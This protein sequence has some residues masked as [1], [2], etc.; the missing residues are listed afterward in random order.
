MAEFIVASL[1]INQI[2]TRHDQSGGKHTLH[3]RPE[4]EVSAREIVREVVE[5]VPPE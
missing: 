1:Q 5:G 3:V 4:D 2:Q